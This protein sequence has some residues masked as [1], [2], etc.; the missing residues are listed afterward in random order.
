MSATGNVLYCGDPHGR[1][2]HIVRAAH[3]G[4]YEAVVVLGDLDLARPL[5]V[6]LGKIAEK[7]WYIPG[8]HDSDADAAWSN[9]CDGPLA[10]RNL[11]GRVIT[12]PS[13]LRL[14]GLGG[15]F[16]GAVWDPSTDRPPTYRTRADHARAT[17]RQHRWRGTH[18]PRK[19]MSTIYPDEI[20]RLASLRADVL[21]MHEAPGYH[22]HG[23]DAL[24]TLARSMGVRVVVHGHHHDSIDSSAGWEQQGFATHGV[25]L[26]GLT[27][28]DADGQTRT[29]LPGELDHVG[30]SRGEGSERPLR[31][32]TTEKGGDSGSR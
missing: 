6:E 3:A 14:A 12:L 16:R 24:D 10:N 23:V 1:F 5:H 7:L 28:I 13:G 26:R 8:N 22:P 15:V 18:P 20:D 31:R 32:A 25:G 29:V 4:A 30:P 2:A 9:L 11:H 19:H 17:P 21:V 27:V